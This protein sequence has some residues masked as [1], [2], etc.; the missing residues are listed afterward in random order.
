MAGPL[1]AARGVGK[2]TR[3]RLALALGGCTAGIAGTPSPSRE[4]AP[5]GGCPCSCWL[6]VLSSSSPVSSGAHPG[7]SGGIHPDLGNS[8]LR[9]ATGRDTMRDRESVPMLSSP[10]GFRDPDSTRLPTLG[11]PLPQLP[12]PRVPPELGIPGD[13]LFV[14]L[15]DSTCS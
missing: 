12:R 3:R 2:E 7:Y 8:R 10:S 6:C 14:A 1:A 13:A 15:W 5:L 4:Y 9:T 11:T